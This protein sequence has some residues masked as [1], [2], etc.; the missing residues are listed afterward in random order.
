M[1]P[2]TIY[3]I[4]GKYEL[5]DCALHDPKEKPVFISGLVVFLCVKS[6]F[7]RTDFVAGSPRQQSTFQLLQW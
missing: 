7:S 5:K 1:K 2:F 3:S 4:A 6:D